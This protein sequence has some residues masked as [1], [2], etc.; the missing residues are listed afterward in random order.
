MGT[1]HKCIHTPS[2]QLAHVYYP[3][4]EHSQ[5]HLKE[6]SFDLQLHKLLERKRSLSRDVLLPPQTGTEATE[7]Y[8]MV[9]RN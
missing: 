9:H 8:G 4:A 5:P 1:K 3:L 7:L 6:Y 2:L